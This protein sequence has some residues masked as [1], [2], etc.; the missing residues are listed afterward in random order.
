MPMPPGGRPY[1]NLGQPNHLAMLLLLGLV[2]AV[3]ALQRQRIGT[4]G[5]SLIVGFVGTALVATQSRTA[6]V[7]ALFVVLWLACAHSRSGLQV[8]PRALVAAGIAFVTLTFAW[9]GL[10]QTIDVNVSRGTTEMTEQGT[11]PTLWP[12]F[13]VAALRSPWIG[14]GW[15]QVVVAQ[16]EVA[17][18]RPAFHELLD[19]S[20][21][22][23]IDLV[24]WNGAPVGLLIIAALVWWFAR[25][26]RAARTPAQALLLAALVAVIVHAMFEYPLSYA[27]FLLPSALM[28]GALEGLR[29]VGARIRVSAGSHGGTYGRHDRHNGDRRCRLRGYRR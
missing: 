9:P 18:S 22:L 17:A 27:Y 25:Q 2:G 11:R 16:G 19:H 7:A 6:I 8:A 21:N 14:Y 1:G 3:W 29:P 23:V 13:V 24:L 26:M 20:H 5:L 15:N 12:S 10:L 28:I 4:I